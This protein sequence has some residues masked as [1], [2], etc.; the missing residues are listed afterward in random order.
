MKS[1]VIVSHIAVAAVVWFVTLQYVD[2]GRGPSHF[3]SSTAAESRKMPCTPFSVPLVGRFMLP[4]YAARLREYK[5]QHYP[6]A[7][8]RPLRV[9]EVGSNRCENAFSFLT[10]LKEGMKSTPPVDV[11]LY[12]VDSWGYRGE[13][14]RGAWQDNNN[15]TEGVW[16]YNR[17]RHVLSRA[18]PNTTKLIRM[19]SEKAA[20]KFEDEFFDFVYI[21]AL[22][23]YSMSKLDLRVWWPK[24]V[25]G[26]LLGGDDLG[27]LDV[28]KFV[29]KSQADLYTNFRWGVTTAVKEFIVDH[30]LPFYTTFSETKIVGTVARRLRRLVDSILAEWRAAPISEKDMFPAVL[31]VDDPI[32]GEP[33]YYSVKPFEGYDRSCSQVVMQDMYPTGALA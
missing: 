30:G 25:P 20:M 31:P 29:V 27:G 7:T 6:E 24:L 5:L 26:G 4:I 33:N 28:V 18:F 14:E 15:D 9:V 22:H 2:S 23:T 16:N 8:P 10:M 12:L 21:D 1:S 11:E 17:C 32:R 3:S 13:E 19:V